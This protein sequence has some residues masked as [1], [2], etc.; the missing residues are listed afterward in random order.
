MDF[1]Q[2]VIRCV[3][4]KYADFNGR[5]SRPEFWWFALACFLVAVVFNLL[6]L[7]L[8][9]A[10]VNLAL[11]LPSLAV[12]SRRLHDIGKSG[13]FQLIWLIPLIGWAIMIY[14]L[15]QPSAGPNEYGEGPAPADVPAEMPPGTA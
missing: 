10:L 4:D 11:L 15:V 6:R 12:G 8:L 7:E 13:W 3:R 2:S 14:W 1:K 5:A 9:G